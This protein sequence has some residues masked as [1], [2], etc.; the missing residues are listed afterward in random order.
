VIAI[1]FAKIFVFAVC[2]ATGFIGG[3]SS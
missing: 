2:E 1:V 3:P